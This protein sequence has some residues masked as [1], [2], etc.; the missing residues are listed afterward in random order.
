MLGTGVRGRPMDSWDKIICSD[1]LK[2][3]H[4][5][6]HLLIGLPGDS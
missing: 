4:G 6:E 3:T 1:L 5:T 2:L